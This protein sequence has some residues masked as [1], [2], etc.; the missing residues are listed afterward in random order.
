MKTATEDDD[1]TSA[2][3]MLSQLNRCLDGLSSRVGEKEAGKI[4][5][6]NC[7]KRGDQLQ[8]RLVIDDVHLSM[9]EFGSLLLNGLDHLRMAM[10]GVS[11]SDPAGEV[12]VAST[13]DI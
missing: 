1:I 11:Y 5:G 13:M 2:S 4:F 10:A 6:E 9:N 3:S 12:E 8:G 7:Q